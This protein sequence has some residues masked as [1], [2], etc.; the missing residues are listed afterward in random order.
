LESLN[1]SKDTNRAQENIEENIKTCLGNQDG[2]KL[3]GTRQLLVYADDVNTLG[4]SVHTATNTDALV[5]PI[6]VNGLQVNADKTKCMV[7]TRDQISGRSHNKKTGNS[8]CER[9]EHI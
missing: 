1:N 5:V 2:L 8:C 9:M 3:N 6:K 7:I 4:R